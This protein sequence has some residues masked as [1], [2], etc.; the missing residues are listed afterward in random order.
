MNRDVPIEITKATKCDSSPG[1]AVECERTHLSY[2]TRHAFRIHRAAAALSS[3]ET[4]ALA[5]SLRCVWVNVSSVA[6]KKCSLDHRACL[7]A[8]ASCANDAVALRLGPYHSRVS[9]FNLRP[10]MIGWLDLT[11][12]ILSACLRCWPRSRDRIS[13][14]ETGF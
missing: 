5:Y 2:T 12:E 14:F 4:R 10:R 3:A 8:L 9:G 6:R 11:N 7:L 13:S 1:P